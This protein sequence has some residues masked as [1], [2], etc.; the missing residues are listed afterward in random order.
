[1]IHPFLAFSGLCCVALLA[2]LSCR[3]MLRAAPP[4]SDE[5]SWGVLIAQACSL[6]LIFL[7]ICVLSFGSAR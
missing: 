6:A 3:D 5:V 2:L 7:G 1:M 4:V